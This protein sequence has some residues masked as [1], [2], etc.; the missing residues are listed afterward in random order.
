MCQDSGDNTRPI[1]HGIEDA[2]AQRLGNVTFLFF[3]LP[4]AIMKI[5]I[6]LIIYFRA[7]SGCY[8]KHIYRTP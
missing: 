2:V 7:N 4:Q 6:I 3:L 8:C 1:I 5:L